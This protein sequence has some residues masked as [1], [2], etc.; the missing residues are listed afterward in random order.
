MEWHILLHKFYFAPGLA[1]RWLTTREPRHLQAWARLTDGWLQQ[2]RDP[3]FIASDVTGR[4]VQ[5]WTYALHLL[6][7]DGEATPLDAAL[8]RR[9]LLSLHTQVEHLCSHL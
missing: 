9:V 5:N 4:R 8:V 2:V 3:G 6:L 1:Q 7:A